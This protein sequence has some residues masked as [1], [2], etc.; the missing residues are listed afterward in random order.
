MKEF[1][2][3]KGLW[4]RYNPYDVAAIY[5]DAM[6]KQHALRNINEKM[7][8][9]LFMMNG[10]DTPTGIDYTF[11]NDIKDAPEA[12]EF[13]QPRNYPTDITVKMLLLGASPVRA[14]AFTMTSW[15]WIYGVYEE[16]DELVYINCDAIYNR[17]WEIRRSLADNL[18]HMLSELSIYTSEAL[19]KQVD[20]NKLI[21][22]AKGVN[23]E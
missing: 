2:K 23:N 16:L 22:L 1:G 10:M 7:Y 20:L 17:W 5:Y 12:W 8:R 3:I 13:V 4:T 19:N 21:E 15:P 18:A 11:G 14:A 6:I 9:R